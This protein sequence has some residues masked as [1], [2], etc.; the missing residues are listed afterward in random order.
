MKISTA[1]LITADGRIIEVSPRDGKKFSLPELQ[2]Y[3]HGYIEI[4]RLPSK[5]GV[6]LVINEEGKLEWLPKNMLATKMWQEKSDP[7]SDRAADD[8]VGDCLLCT[9]NQID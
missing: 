3:V 5:T 7:N 1:K 2:G 8:I 9:S 6:V 4:V